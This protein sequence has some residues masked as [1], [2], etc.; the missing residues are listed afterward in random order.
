MEENKRVSS[1]RTKPKG[2]FA[3]SCTE[4][5]P[6]AFQSLGFIQPGTRYVLFVAVH[7]PNHYGL[8]QPK[9]QAAVLGHSLVRSLVHSHPSLIRLLQTARSSALTRSLAHSLRSLPRSWESKLLDG[10]FV[11]IFFHYRP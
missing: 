11:C 10:Y 3:V 1:C 7:S 2:T 8:E 6:L 9:I 4:K 5:L